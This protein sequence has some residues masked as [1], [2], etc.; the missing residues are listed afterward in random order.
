MELAKY[1]DRARVLIQSA[2]GC[3]LAAE[4]QQLTP[5]HI[6]NE[7]LQNEMDPIATLLCDLSGN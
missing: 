2:Q 1:T 6:L 4:H 7:L 3:A 5:E